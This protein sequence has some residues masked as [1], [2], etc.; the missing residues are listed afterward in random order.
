[1]GRSGFDLVAT[2]SI[3]R[4][5]GTVVTVCVGPVFGVVCYDYG[6]D[7]C[8]FEKPL[9]SQKATGAPILDLIRGTNPPQQAA[10]IYAP[11][12]VLA[13]LGGGI[14]TVTLGIEAARMGEIWGGVLLLTPAVV[15]GLLLAVIPQSANAGWYR[16]TVV[17]ADIDADMD[18]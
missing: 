6:F 17:V 4:R 2:P 16:A 13:L 18:T 8:V 10:F 5:M 1:M 12:V 14:F 15:G 7:C 3:L 11:G 9:E